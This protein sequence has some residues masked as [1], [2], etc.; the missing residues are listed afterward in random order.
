MFHNLNYDKNVF[1][2]S[3]VHIKDN[4][5]NVSILADNSNS[6]KAFTINKL[7]FIDTVRFM[8]SSLAK[9]ISNL[10]E[11]DMIFMKSLNDDESKFKYIKQK[12]Y[13][14]YEWF[15]SI[16]KFKLPISEL[17]KEHFDN[18]LTLSKI[19]ESEWEY[20]QEL[21]ENNNIHTFEDFHDF[22]LHIDVNGLADVFE[23]FRKTSLEYYKLD[24]CGYVGTPSFAW[25]A[26]LLKDNVKLEL[27]KDIDMYLILEKGI[28]GG[29]SV[30]FKKHAEVNNKYLENYDENKP[31]NYIT[32]L[33]AN[34][35]YG[36]AMNHKLPI[37]GFKWVDNV[38]INTIMNYT[39][40]NDIGYILEVD[41]EYP[42]EL[43]K[44]HNDY[45]LA[46]E[47]F[48]P[49][50]S[51]CEKLCGTF[52]DKKDYV[53]HISNLKYYLEKG[54][55]LK[56][57]N[58]CIQ[59]N[60]SAW[61]SGWVQKNTQYRQASKNEFEKDY[62]K[63]M[64][65]AVFGKT[66]ENVRDRFDVKCAFDEEYSKKYISKLN[67]STYEKI[68]DDFMLIKLDKKTVKLDKPIYAGFSI[69]DLSKLHMFKFHYDVMKP[70]YGD[71]IQL[72]MTDTDSL[73]YEIQTEDIYKDMFEMKQHFDMSSYGKQNPIYDNTNN[74]VIGK[75]K[76]ETGDKI[77]T[78]FV[79]VRPKC[80]SFLTNDNVE[81][82]KLKGITKCV[83]KKNIKHE[84][85]KKCV[86]NEL[87]DNDK[88]VNVNSIRTKNFS[89]YS[90]VQKK[91]AL[92]N[93]DDK[94]NWNGIHSTAYGYC[95]N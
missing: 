88:Y 30:I 78:E 15:D 48:K 71:N 82:K 40:E 31:S 92:D 23:S 9:L 33:D 54:I 90:L 75:F 59:F 14:P 26:M 37:S 44:N 2:K 27:I 10:P 84:H 28:R 7:K 43:H 8:N 89:N 94:R 22:Y 17:K 45:P 34:N 46:P 83:V 62:F 52:Y 70:K 51:K 42:K 57:I 47:K 13:F 72:L 77:I 18:Q 64:N 76:D 38:D 86:F 5:K 41:L 80:Y 1:F 95:E 56:S 32:Y 69:L 85:Y 11:S 50:G 4:I 67:C 25:D 16:E 68:C 60:Q 87:T 35:L 93:N 3:L 91:K 20:I 81:N 53:V 79:G 19:D 73:V 21:I 74:K 36:E 65:N 61:L 49:V 55:K 66:M 63:L 6:Y 24:P 39:E 12:G 29:Q 58:R